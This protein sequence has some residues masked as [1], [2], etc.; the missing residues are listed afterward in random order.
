MRLQR[1]MIAS[2]LAMTMAAL[3]GGPVW[4][5][6]ARITVQAP[7]GIGGVPVLPLTGIG[8]LGALNA[9]ALSPSLSGLTPLPAPSAIAPVIQAAPAFA[10]PVSAVKAAASAPVA[11]SPAIDADQGSYTALRAMQL[12]AAAEGGEKKSSEQSSADAR[13]TFDGQEVAAALAPVEALPSRLRAFL[14]SSRSAVTGFGQDV[15]GMATG[16]KELEPL[17]GDAKPSMRKTQ[18][19]LVLDAVLSIGMAFIVGPLLDTAAI[20]AKTGLAA[21]MVPLAILSG[22]LVLSSLVYAWVERSH[23]VQGRLASLRGFDQQRVDLRV[24]F[25]VQARKVAH[26]HLACRR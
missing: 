22:A 20:A 6:T 4:A 9:P 23:A 26:A 19:L 18:I 25:W 16:D 17:L 24:L 5:Q 13:K 12:P 15:K 2:F 11:V 3:A 21:H 7:M 10:A 14:K 8:S 1:R